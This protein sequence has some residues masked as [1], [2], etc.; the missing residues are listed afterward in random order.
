M[1]RCAPTFCSAIAARM[2]GASAALMTMDG[3][4]AAMSNCGGANKALR[5]RPMVA[6]A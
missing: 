5:Y 6:Y 1:Q 2:S 3:L 4:P